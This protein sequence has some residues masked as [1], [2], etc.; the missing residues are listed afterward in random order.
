M[1]VSHVGV[2][3]FL[4]CTN[5]HNPYRVGSQTSEGEAKASPKKAR[6]KHSRKS[7]STRSGDEIESFANI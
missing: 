3:G 7:A 2:S 4:E 1:H 5:D 6:P